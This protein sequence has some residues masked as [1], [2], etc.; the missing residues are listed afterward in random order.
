[1]KKIILGLLTVGVLAALFACT[2]VPETSPASSGDLPW[3]MR[4]EYLALQ[5]KETNHEIT[6]DVL[7]TK[8][9]ALLKSNAARSAGDVESVVTG[10]ERYTATFD[11]GFIENGNNGEKSN[12]IPFYLFKLENKSEKTEGYALACGDTRICD[13]LAIVDEGDIDFENPFVQL[14][15]AN[16][17]DYVMETIEIYNNISAEDIIAATEK[18]E[19]IHRVTSRSATIP[20]VT[21]GPLTVTKWDQNTPYWNVI[22]SIYNRSS[23]KYYTGCVVTAVAQIMAYHNWPP[24]PAM[25]IRD[26]IKG[27]KLDS[28]PDPYNGGANVRFWDLYYIWSGTSRISGMNDISPDDDRKREIGVLMFEIGSNVNITYGTYGSGGSNASTESV[29]GALRNMRYLNSSVV[30]Y[31]FATIRTSIDRGEPVYVSGDS[32]RTTSYPWWDIF[33]NNPQYSYGAGHAWVIDGYKIQNYVPYVHCNIGWGGTSNG[34]YISGVFDTKN[35]PIPTR[36]TIDTPKNYQ[37]NQKIIPFI[38]YK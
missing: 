26:P 25:Y 4:E 10:V 28:F 37:F 38:N 29:P 5:H 3:L 30:S 1:M 18:E 34:W 32:K 9:T 8:L 24:Y 23:D 22:N 6:G 15:Y 16:L 36:S 20:D 27:K 13:I 7:Q 19:E 14:F 33:K 2:F 35:V 17:A 21:V 11:N 31:N 12:E